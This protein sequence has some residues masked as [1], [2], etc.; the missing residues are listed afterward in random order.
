MPQILICLAYSVYFY[1]VRGIR[2]ENQK[3]GNLGGF[4]DNFGKKYEQFWIEW[5]LQ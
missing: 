5:T 1:E 2:L 4:F 3:V